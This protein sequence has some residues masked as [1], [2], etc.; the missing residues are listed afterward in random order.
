M[1]TTLSGWSKDQ[2]KVLLEVQLP[3]WQENMLVSHLQEGSNLLKLFAA[4]RYLDDLRLSN[5]SISQLSDLA[6]PGNNLQLFAAADSLQ[7]LLN[8][9]QASTS[10]DQTT[11][12]AMANAEVREN[13]R[14]ALVSYLLQHKHIINLQLEDADILF[15]YFLIDGSIDT[16]ARM[17]R[18]QHDISAVQF[19]VQ[20][21]LLGL[22]KSYGVKISDLKHL[23]RKWTPLKTYKIWEAKR[24]ISFDPENSHVITD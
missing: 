9:T 20:R 23:R 15:E 21:C 3:G 19:Y 18:F 17:S 11:S 4:L 12:F 14:T 8:T 2:F 24:K 6:L 16:Q 22:G 1:L 7:S 5:V 10:A 13:Q